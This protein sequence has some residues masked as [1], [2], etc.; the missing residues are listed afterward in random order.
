MNFLKK[1]SAMMLI[2]AMVACVMCGCGNDAQN[3]E[4]TGGS[5]NTADT[6]YTVTVVDQNGN[7]VANVIMQLTDAEGGTQLAVT[8]ATG[9][10]TATSVTYVSVTLSS[11]PN[12]YSSDVDVVEFG[13]EKDLVITL[14]ADE[15][16]STDITYTVTIVDQNGKP[17]PG[18]TLQLC[19]DENCKL[20]VVTDE[21]GTAS[22]TYE[23]ADYHVS[24]TEI[25]DGYSS[26][27]TSFEF[28]GSTEITIVINAE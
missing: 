5:G 3:T 11:I 6:S 27:E 17:V 19:D 21:S 16:V 8:D 25:P 24:L 14:Q 15:V 20:P 2:V 26:E 7:P 22:C 13:S 18:V 23:E 9:V 4:S 10:V 12:G 1:I 28:G